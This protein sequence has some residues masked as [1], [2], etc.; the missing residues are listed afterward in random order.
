[1]QDIVTYIS[2]AL[3]LGNDKRNHNLE[4]QITDILVNELFNIKNIVH[5]SFYIESYGTK[6]IYTI[7]G[8]KYLQTDCTVERLNLDMFSNELNINIKTN[9][10]QFGET[11][12]IIENEKLKIL[13]LIYVSAKGYIEEISISENIYKRLINYIK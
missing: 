3:K 6:K 12:Y 1:M 10:N 5:D 13:L 11:K 9:T 4:K 8:N 7:Y 2:E